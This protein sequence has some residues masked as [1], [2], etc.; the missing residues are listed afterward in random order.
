[1][2]TKINILSLLFIQIIIIAGFT[3]CNKKKDEPVP[4]NTTTNEPKGRLRFHL[5]DYLEETEIDLYNH[6]YT[7]E[8]GD[9]ISISTVSLYLSEIELIR[10]DGSAY[11][12]KD[13]I[14]YKEPEK[15][16]YNVADVPVGNYKSIR[17]KVG[18]APFA[19]NSSASVHPLL[20]K[21]EMW[22]GPTQGSGIVYFNIKGKKNDKDF[23]YKIGTESNLKQVSMPEKNYSVTPNGTSYVHMIID[24]AKVLSEIDVETESNRE[25]LT[26]HCNGK[27]LAKQISNR[28]PSMFIY[29]D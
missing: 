17:F 7:L 29:E 23:H 9:K 22:F 25:I 20:N 11:L 8:N 27:E 4:T 1:M 16:T 15:F 19:T 18:V 3:S 26:H 12:I 10:L 21:P 14:V 28:I 5:H 13:S 6:N 2:K 24:Y